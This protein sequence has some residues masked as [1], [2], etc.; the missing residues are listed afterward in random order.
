MADRCARSNARGEIA[1]NIV[2]PKLMY[3]R[4]GFET[5]LQTKERRRKEMVVL[6][7]TTDQMD[8]LFSCFDK[9]MI[10]FGRVKK[11][12]EKISR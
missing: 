6:K 7:K 2:N 5:S 3:I 4:S 11:L 8:K 9:N 12:Y 10:A 1:W